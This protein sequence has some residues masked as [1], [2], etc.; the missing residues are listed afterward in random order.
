[1]D[2]HST[3]AMGP[4]ASQSGMGMPMPARKPLAPEVELRNMASQASAFVQEG[5]M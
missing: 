1:M 2:M 4:Y 3:M 5:I